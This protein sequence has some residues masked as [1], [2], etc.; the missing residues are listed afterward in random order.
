[1]RVAPPILLTD[2]QRHELSV[3]ASSRSVSVRF[4]RRATMILPAAEGRQDIQ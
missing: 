3:A 4:A 2:E 1:M